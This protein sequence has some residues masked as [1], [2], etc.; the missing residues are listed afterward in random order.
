MEAGTPVRRLRQAIEREFACHR[1]GACCKGEGLVHVGAGEAKALAEAL[2]MDR[3]AFLARF[4]RSDG[5][6]HWILRD[7]IAKLRPVG[8]TQTWCVFLERH[9]DGHYGCQVNGAKPRQCATFPAAWRNPDSMSD[10]V[11]LRRL[12]GVLDASN[13]A[14]GQAR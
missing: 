11:G 9:A 12:Q 5:P 2:G 3:D 6:G 7:K 4:A 13:A 1:C 10:C 14:A 8:P